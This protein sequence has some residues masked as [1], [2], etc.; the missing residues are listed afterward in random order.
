M[1]SD[2]VRHRT[3]TE[4]WKN[5]R[6]KETR[7][8]GRVSFCVSGKRRSFFSAK[9]EPLPGQ[10]LFV[11]S[12]YSVRMYSGSF[13]SGISVVKPSPMRRI[14]VRVMESP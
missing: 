9:K 14:S 3:N 2:P 4:A 11:C 12:Y 13:S 6:K 10:R 8:I 7:L 1:G 5:G